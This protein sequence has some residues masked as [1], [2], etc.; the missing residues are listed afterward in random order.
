MS[1]RPWRLLLAAGLA[2][3]T[4]GCVTSTVDES[5][6]TVDESASTAAEST[7][8]EG[9]AN[10]DG[11]GP[12]DLVGFLFAVPDMLQQKRG[13][14][15]DTIVIKTVAILPDARY[16]GLGRLLIVEMLRNAQ[17][18]GYR[19]AISALMHCQ[20]RSQVISRDCARPMREYSLFARELSS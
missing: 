18:L 5:T 13:Q 4:S 2:L 17:A 16:R 15:P 19:Q 1:A 20:N 8:A 14:T 10:G 9:S 11:D 7:S 12:G 6:S 3:A